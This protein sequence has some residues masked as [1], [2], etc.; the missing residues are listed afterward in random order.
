MNAIS[1]DLA[2]RRPE[3]LFGAS[4]L[5]RT[6]LALLVATAACSEQLTFEEARVTS[7]VSNASSPTTAA[8][9][10]LSVS[11][12][13]RDQ[14]GRGVPGQSVTF[15]PSA[16]TIAAATVTSDT[17]GVATVTWTPGTTAGAQTVTAAVPSASVSVQVSATITPGPA[18]SGALSRTNVTVDALTD[19]VR[20]DVSNV[21]DAFNNAISSATV[22]WVSSDTTVAS[23]VSPGLFRSRGNGVA[24]VSARVGTATIASTNFTVAQ[25]P[26]TLVLTPSRSRVVAVNDS[27][28]LTVTATDRLSQAIATPSGVT[29]T[30]SNAAAVTVPLASA[31][32]VRAAGTGRATITATRGAL[33]ASV[34]VAAGAAVPT[35]VVALDSARVTS[36]N[37]TATLTASTVDQDTI[38]M[39]GR[40][41]TFTS[42]QPSIATVAATGVATSVTGGLAQIVVTDAAGGAIVPDTVPFRVV[43][44]PASIVPS[45]DT[46]P[47]PQSDTAAFTSLVRDSAGATIP[48][49]FPT[50]T[51]G[52]PGTAT[53]SVTAGTTRVAGIAAG[54]ATLTLTVGTAPAVVTRTVVA[55]VDAAARWKQIAGVGYFMCG[56]TTTDE[57]Y[58]WGGAGN[59]STGFGGTN[60]DS[61]S[62]VPRRPL[63]TATLR[64]AQL[65]VSSE[66]V[67]ALQTAATGG[68]VYCWGAGV[69]GQLGVNPSS[70]ASFTC[71]TNT[72][73]YRNSPLAL[74]SVFKFSAIQ[75]QRA[76]FCGIVSTGGTP[77]RVACWGENYGQQ[78]GIPSG[79]T[80]T[81][82]TSPVLITDTTTFVRLTAINDTF[83]GVAARDNLTYCWGGAAWGLKGATQATTT[84]NAATYTH[85]TNVLSPTLHFT[86]FG[87]SA[88][89]GGSPALC[90]IASGQVHCWGYNGWG[91]VGTG[92]INTTRNVP[93]LV[94]GVTGTATSV[95]TNGFSTCATN[96]AGNVFCWGANGAGQLGVTTSTSCV[97]GGADPQYNFASQPLITTSCAPAP[98]QVPTSLTFSSVIVAGHRDTGPSQVTCA[99]RPS[100]VAYCWGSGALGSAGAAT[101]TPRLVAAP[102]N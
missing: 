13:V 4:F 1:V 100:G 52:T 38:P 34:V 43:Q 72:C 82:R 79:G 73:R 67:C 53:V 60:K 26:V 24:T 99:L 8:G 74:S 81:I 98:V 45:A 77:G 32:V 25:V 22:T 62:V 51:S 47:V 85:L 76:G 42:L 36:S 21:R 14:R 64:F 9:S 18:A 27:L 46:V 55:R 90:G 2:A 39:T 6:L 95:S 11:V 23:L 57:V 33:T 97:G 19:T 87:Q 89:N 65:S 20:F 48:S 84:G 91:A 83:C 68:D 70:L 3:R 5:R 93:T 44:V 96:A 49:V 10:S 86:A 35:R 94:T 12:T 101:T 92:T 29:F 63:N 102:A 41:F 56:L 88:A 7:V 28:R 16:G 71:G 69:Q 78:L 61:S 37:R 58:C 59:G 31:P 30:T 40:T 66:A 54:A 50:V 80:D 75:A 17:A 15:T